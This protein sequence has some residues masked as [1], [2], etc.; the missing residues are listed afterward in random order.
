MAG[1][2]NAS[3]T[4]GIGAR[5]SEVQKI[6]SDRAHADYEQ[7][8]RM[9]NMSSVVPMRLSETPGHNASIKI[10][11]QIAAGLSRIQNYLRKIVAKIR[12]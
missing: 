1:I 2:D 7:L 11:Y 9:E 10:A 5:M 6:V 4:S 8:Q 12:Q 3:E